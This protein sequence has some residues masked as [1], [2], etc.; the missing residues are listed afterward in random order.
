[1]DAK[2]NRLVSVIIPTY[3][4]AKLLP[5]AIES[6]LSQT[7]TNWELYIVDDGSTDD[8]ESVVG[9]YVNNKIHYIKCDHSGV[10][11]VVRNIGIRKARG[12]WVAFLDDD[13]LWLPN[14]LE[15]QIDVVNR[16]KDVGLICTNGYRKTQETHKESFQLYFRLPARIAD[17]CFEDL[18]RDNFVI[19]SSVLVRRE[20]LL[21]VGGYDED[22]RICCDYELWLRLSLST[23]F[24]RIE[25]PL[26]IY[27]DIPKQS[28][29]ADASPFEYYKVMLA[30]YLGIRRFQYQKQIARSKILD[31]KIVT[32]SARIIEEYLYLKVPLLTSIKSNL[33]K[34]LREKR[35]RAYLGNY[36]PNEQTSMDMGQ[37]ST[38]DLRHYT[39]QH[40]GAIR[41]HLGCGERYFS[42]YINI[43]YSPSKRTTQVI[44]P[45]NYYH[46]IRTLHFPASSVAEIRLHHVFEHFDRPTALKLLINW[47][48]W[49]IN[50]GELI[51]EVP[52]FNR[53]AL[54]ILNPFTNWQ[55]KASAMRHLYGSHEAHWAYHYEG[56]NKQRL[57]LTL[58]KLGFSSMKFHRTRW[59]KTFNITVLARKQ[60]ALAKKEL[61]IRAINLLKESLI[62]ESASECGI[63][64]TWRQKL[65]E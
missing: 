35:R 39:K 34:M 47:Y 44:S 51:I 3:N 42:G 53:C 19:H 33:R 41:L 7:Y 32:T 6:I 11:A 14:K 62:D 59:K 56:W 40:Y 50:G 55:R 16:R 21:S 26:V 60:T 2:M 22:R 28:L 29:R 17:F 54:R 64:D 24:E 9:K 1:M 63:L 31:M 58:K 57:E 30:I 8:T 20:A 45:A 37:L 23:R 25:Q 38:K 48:T 12:E 61:K 15:R 49:L 5:S 43:D 36:P 52:D 10:H 18:V 4:R 13:D 65:A 27:R 46:D